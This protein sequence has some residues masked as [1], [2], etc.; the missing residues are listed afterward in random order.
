LGF[1]R[2]QEEKRMKTMKF[3][4][5]VL[6]LAAVLA[7]A[8]ACAAP[9]TQPGAVQTVVVPQTVEVP[10]TAAPAPVDQAR[11]E[12]LNIA[13][14]KAMISPPADDVNPYTNWDRGFGMHNLCYEYFFYQNLQTGEYIPWLATGYEYSPDFTSLTVNL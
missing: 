12:T 11:A 9:V 4:L 5:W 7:V 14:D 10:V 1:S 6:A 13:I 2:N 3:S 8:A